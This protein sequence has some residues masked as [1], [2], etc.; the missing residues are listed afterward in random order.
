MCNKNEESLST[1]VPSTPF[2]YFTQSHINNNSNTGSHHPTLYLYSEY[3]LPNCFDSKINMD[4]PFLLYPLNLERCTRTYH[5][6]QASDSLMKGFYGSYP[7][8]CKDSMEIQMLIGL[9]NTSTLTNTSS[10]MTDIKT[11]Y[12]NDTSFSSISLP[13]TPF[14]VQ[15]GDSLARSRTV[16]IISKFR[17]HVKDSTSVALVTSFVESSSSSVLYVMVSWYMASY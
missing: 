16:P 9:N 5:K 12:I 15:F 14:I 6:N 13:Q 11:I 10:T 4:V 3:G 7:F 1:T 17:M 8:Y 2:Y